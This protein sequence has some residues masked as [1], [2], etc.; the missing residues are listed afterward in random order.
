MAGRIAYTGGIVTNGLILNL[1]AAKRDSYPGS[2]TIWNDISGFRNNG[3][4]TNGPTF[5]SADYGSIVFD[6]VDD[7]VQT[8]ANVILTSMTLMGFIKRNGS[9]PDFAGIYFSRGTSVTGLNFNSTTNILGYHYNG[10][11]FSFNSSLLVPNNQWCM[12]AISVIPTSA[13]LYVNTNSAVNSNVHAST[14]IN[15][16]KVGRDRDGR[17]INGNVGNMLFYNRALTTPEITQNYNALKGRYG[18]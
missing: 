11:Y 4:L 2:G 17:V 1:D 16:L 10:D 13:T 18:L 8:S 12:V 6:G 5:S 9:Q 3:T 14:T 7:F 15:S